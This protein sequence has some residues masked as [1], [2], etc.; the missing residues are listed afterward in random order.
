MMSDIFVKTYEAPAYN[1]EDILRYAGVS[2]TVPA[3]VELMNSCL[4][5]TRDTW[6]YR[7]CYREFPVVHSDERL[8]LTFAE[9]TS[10]HL[11]RNLQNCDSIVLFAATVGI[12]IDRL[13]ARYAHTSPARMV[14]LHAIGTERIEALCDC[15]NREVAQEKA[16]RGKQTAPRFSPGYGDL[17]LVLQKDVFQVLDCPR[18]IGV[19]LNESL[20]M[21][22][23]K[24]VTA[25]IGVGAIGE[26]AETENCRRMFDCRMCGRETCA[27]KR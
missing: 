25:I 3:M 18:K 5:E 13:A 2:R 22:P 16:A 10:K 11:K 20:L 12:E 27:Y 1:E 19:S 4:E 26:Q 9:T 6:S 24:S 23:S 8:Q 21:V 15:F 7:V 17:P 14:M